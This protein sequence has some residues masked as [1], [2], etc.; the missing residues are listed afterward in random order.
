MSHSDRVRIIDDEGALDYA[1]DVLI[2]PSRLKQFAKV[3]QQCF[4]RFI[5]SL[6]SKVVHSTSTINPSFVNKGTYGV[7]SIAP[8]SGGAPKQ[9]TKSEILKIESPVP[10][11]TDP[12][13]AKATSG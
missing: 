9:R 4:G 7:I 1:P 3:E 6:F 8:L 2:L 11:A 12:P 13:V 5:N 10:A